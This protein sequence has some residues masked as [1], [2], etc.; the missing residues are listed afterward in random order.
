MRARIRERR[1]A[2]RAAGV[3]GLAV[4][5]AVFRTQPAVNESGVIAGPAPLT[6]TFNTCRST[7]LDP[8]DALKA[9]FDFDGDGVVDFAGAGAG[10][11]ATHT[12]EASAAAIVCVTDRNPESEV[13]RTYRIRIGA[14][15][16]A[17]TVPACAVLRQGGGA[18]FAPTFGGYS[19][20]FADFGV[21]GG[22]GV[23]VT[24]RES[25]G[26]P[27]GSIVDCGLSF[28]DGSFGFGVAVAKLSP[29]VPRSCRLYSYTY[30]AYAPSSSFEWTL[31]DPGAF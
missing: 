30:T 14:E 8:G 24:T 18:D 13:C 17:P 6:V 5:D 22:D 3:K 1:R 4:P 12:Y 11:R 7:D 9:R 28:Y 19:S 26:N 23:F 16:P 21:D 20:V 31:C 29:S 25:G 27:V 15:P 10:C 2:R